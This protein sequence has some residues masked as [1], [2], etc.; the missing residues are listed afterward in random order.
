MDYQHICATP[1]EGGLGATIGQVDLSQPQG[2]ATFAEI[3]HAFGEYAVIF[4]RDQHLTPEQHLAFA[5]RWGDINVN[6][7]FTPVAGHPQIAEV[8]KEPDQKVN[9]GGGWHTD[10]SYDQIPALGSILLARKIPEAGGDTLFASMYGVYEGL[11][12]GLKKTLRGLNAVHSSRH[13]FGK[14]AAVSKAD[15]NRFHNA[16][17]ATQDAIH[18]VVIEHPETRRP[19]LYINRAFTLRFEGWT[20]PE[21]RPLLE[22]LYEQAIREENITRFHWEAGSI[23]M[24]DNRSTWHYALNDYQGQRRLMHRVTIEGV[25]LEA[26]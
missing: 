26:A 20:G 14:N 3:Q 9:V 24:W 21:S 11:S 2:D 18:P 13:V 7:F 5:K 12:D 1:S 10:H 4:F 15:G 8:R 25:A 16:E 6:R 17:Q 22:H 23:A 19:A